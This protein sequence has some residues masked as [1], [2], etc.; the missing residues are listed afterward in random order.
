MKF[1]FSNNTLLV[2]KI[3]KR[4]LISER[5][6]KPIDPRGS[7]SGNIKSGLKEAMGSQ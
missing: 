6:P 5:V 4:N 2:G 3:W 7:S 1:Y